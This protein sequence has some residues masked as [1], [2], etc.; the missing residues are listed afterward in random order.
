MPIST[1]TEARDL[2]M[3]HFTTAWDAQTP[4][5][6]LLLYDDRHRDLPDNAP[7]ARITMRH[8]VSDQRTLGNTGNRR[9]RRFGVITVQIFALSNQ[10]LATADTFAKV[11]LD[12]FEGNNTAPTEV[13]FRNVRM[14]EVGEDGPWFQ[15]NVIADFD[16]DEIK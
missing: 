9:F 7:Y 1:F 12:A 5:V 11:A 10:G 6:P 14:N 16:Y 15:T 4:P 8:N 3:L 2:V 13:H